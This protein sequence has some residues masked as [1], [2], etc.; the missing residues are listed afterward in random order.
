MA[1]IFDYL[2]LIF[3]ILKIYIVLS[4]IYFIKQNLQNLDCFFYIKFKTSKIF[5]DD[6]FVTKI[7]CLSVYY[8]KTVVDKNNTRSRNSNN[9]RNIAINR[10][11]SKT[12]NR[13][14]IEASNKVDS[15]INRYK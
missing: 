8:C 4:I 11:K 12:G 10:V 5:C 15:R 3:L 7:S 2:N 6:L 14:N 9:A 13:D 1:K